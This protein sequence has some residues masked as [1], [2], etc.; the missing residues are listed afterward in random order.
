VTFEKG[1]DSI[2]DE[3]QGLLWEH[4]VL[5]ALR[6]RYADE[7][8]FYWLD[9]SQREVDFVLRRGRDHRLHAF[10]EYVIHPWMFDVHVISTPASRRFWTPGLLDEAKD[11]RNPSASQ[12]ECVATHRVESRGKR[13]LPLLAWT[14]P[15]RIASAPDLPQVGGRA[16]RRTS[17]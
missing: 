13:V 17:T 10:D 15:R 8:I 16:V 5:D 3:D 9:K 2:R 6:W 12:T 11:D 1:W 4:L 7:D 14:L